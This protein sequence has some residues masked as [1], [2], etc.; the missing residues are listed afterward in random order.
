MEWHRVGAQVS[1]NNLRNLFTAA[2]RA[3][4]EGASTKDFEP[5]FT[6]VLDFIH[7]NPSCRAEAVSIMSDTIH[8]RNG[9][10]WEL[11][12]FLMRELRWPEVQ[13]AAMSVITRSTD[14]RTKTPLSHVLA[15]FEQDWP[16]EDMYERWRN[17][18]REP[19]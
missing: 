10:P 15:A 4:D 17:T 8:G 19:H 7:Q 3:C 1:A 9:L 12:A 14:W 11:L 5:A 18:M 16:D 13:D 6:A 2:Q